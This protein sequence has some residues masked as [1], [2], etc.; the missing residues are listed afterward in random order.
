VSPARNPADGRRRPWIRVQTD[1]MFDRFG[2]RLQSLFGPAGPGTW[3]AVL[4]AAKRSPVEGVFTYASEEEGWRLLGFSHRPGFTLGEFFD[5]TGA[6]KQTRRRA[7]GQLTD[8]H[9]TRFEQF[10]QW[11]SRPPAGETKPSSRPTNADGVRMESGPDA[12]P[13]KDNDKDRDKDS[14][15]DSTAAGGGAASKEEEVQQVL[16]EWMPLRIAGAIPGPPV[17]TQDGLRRKLLNEIRAD[18]EKIGELRQ[19]IIAAT[20]RPHKHRFEWM[21]DDHDDPRGR[22]CTGCHTWE[23]HE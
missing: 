8:V 2:T 19:Q 7:R 22:Y 1:F 10:Q 5:V 4:A 3:V 11:R 20:P 17:R 21:D 16:D 15:N 12:P 23:N 9:L 13:D 18:S 14:D 6:A